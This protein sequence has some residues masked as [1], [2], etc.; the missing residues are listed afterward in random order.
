M[1]YVK[2]QNK[3]DGPQNICDYWIKDLGFNKTQVVVLDLLAQ[4][5]IVKDYF[6]IVWF[7]NLF[8]SVRLLS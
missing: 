7:D 1:Y 3:D 5:G 6:H 2:G 4:D 8:T